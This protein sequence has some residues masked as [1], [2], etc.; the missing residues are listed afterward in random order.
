MRA[1]SDPAKSVTYQGTTYYFC[2]QRCVERFR[3][4]PEQFLK[5]G[6]SAE[7]PTPANAQVMYTCPMD[8][9]VQQIG[10]GICPKCGMALEPMEAVLI[11]DDGELSAMTKRFWFSLALSVPLL[12]ISMGDMLP[13]VDLHRRLGMQWFNWLQALL[14]TPVV[15]WGGWPFFARAL[16]SI[17]N[18][19]LNMFSLIGMGTSVSYLF[20]LFALL[21]PTVLPEEFKIDGMAPLYFEAAAVIVTLVLMGQ[22][23]ELRARARTNDSVKALL[24]LVPDTVLRVSQ[25]GKELEIPL[26]QVRAGDILRIKPGGKIPVDGTV[27]EGR[28]H[29]DESM[30]TGEPMPVSKQ[31]G[32]RASA[33][34]VNQTGT[35]LLSTDKVGKET[36]LAQIVQMVNQAVRSRAPIQ[37]LADRVSA[38]FVPGVIVSAMVTLALWASIGPAPALSNGLVAAVSVLIIACPCALGLATPISIIIGIGRG[39]TTGVLIKDAT[40]LETM[41]GID[42]LAFDKT[43]TLTEGK[44]QLRHVA[45]T[46]EWSESDILRVAASIEFLSEHPIARTIVESA[47]QRGL[48]L[49]KINDFTSISGQGITGI[50]DGKAIALGNIQLMHACDVDCSA[51][52]K[53][54]SGLLSNANTVIYLGVNRKA[55]GLIGIVDPIKT[56]A[57]AAIRQL[58][59]AGLK[60]VMLTGDNEQSAAIVAKQSGIDEFKANML[61]KDKL[62][63]IKALQ[64]QGMR[65][66]MAGDGINDAPALAQAD[67]GIAMGNGTNIAIQNAGVVL[68]KGDLAGIAKARAL[69]AQTMKNIRQNLFFALVY[70]FIGIPLAAGA[71]FPFFGIVLSPMLASAAMSF[72]SVSVIGNALRLRRLKL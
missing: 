20:S 44:A 1:A 57:V 51:V 58:H 61:P 66:G 18:R 8:P 54:A 56:D 50:L 55:V 32:D 41:E 6:E 60:L 43:G 63:F 34:T 52:E 35:F 2:G 49:D 42:V 45:T 37:R 29:V 11:A 36:L 27:T 31:T 53:E 13:G 39:A 46:N 12:M 4:N 14:A 72:S 67:I 69:S 59:A 64:Q 19:H 70:N 40:A 23:L 28:S 30:I 33:G 38:W 15:A 68:V 71:L 10:P 16:A 48:S 47:N 5:Q 22:V 7:V 26:D 62:D 17:K 9:E 25:D 3:A 21:F 24:Q 65:V